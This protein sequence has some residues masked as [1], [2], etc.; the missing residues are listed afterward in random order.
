MTP[1]ELTTIRIEMSEPRSRLD[2]W[3]QARFPNLSRGTFQRL[4]AEGHLTVGGH[5][6]K[7]THPPRAGDVIEIHWPAPKPAA[8]APEPIPLEVLFE[9]DQLLVLNKPPGRVVHPSAGHEEGTLVNALLHHCA[10][11]LSG[12]GGVARPGIVHR[13][14][15]DTSGCLLVAK[16]DATH[17][18]LAAQFAGREVLKVYLALVCGAPAPAAGEIQ[19]AIARHPT[20]RK[21]MAVTDGSGREAW[22][23]YRVREQW[24]EAA[25]VEAI[26][27]TGRTHQVRVHLRHIGHP[28][29]GDTVYGNRQNQR[30]SQATGYTAPRQM[31]H[32]F[33]LAFV[34][35][36]T[37]RQLAVEAPVPTDFLAAAEILRGPAARSVCR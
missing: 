34:H 26:L 1:G 16:D 13:L 22:T 37:A 11:N 27:H 28:L 32:A 23:T 25:L 36:R 3:L 15:R 20:H 7:P 8:A 30:L 19:A 10:G 18:A 14:D 6:V 29:V 5:P 31:L 4:I 9:D 35:P 24:R 2:R 21:R 12:I 33:K 17:L